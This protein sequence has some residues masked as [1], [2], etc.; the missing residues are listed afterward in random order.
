MYEYEAIVV[1]QAAGIRAAL[2][3]SPNRYDTYYCTGTVHVPRDMTFDDMIYDTSY[4]SDG[5]PSTSTSQRERTC[6]GIWTPGRNYKVYWPAVSYYSQCGI[7]VTCEKEAST[8][9]SRQSMATCLSLLPKL[10]G[11]TYCCT[12]AP[13]TR[14]RTYQVGVVQEDVPDSLLL[15]RE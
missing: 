13:D 3:E 1:Y 2:Y 5:D 10:S 8:L 11:C 9:A 15:P 6:D 14:Q 4:N 12:S 7:Q